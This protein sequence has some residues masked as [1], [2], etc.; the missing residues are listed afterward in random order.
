MH[1]LVITSHFRPE[2]GAAAKRMGGLVLALQFAGHRTTVVTLNA[3]GAKSADSRVTIDAEGDGNQVWRFQNWTPPRNNLRARLWTEARFALLASRF[4]TRMS[5]V[6]GVLASSPYMFNLTA[7]RTYSVP[8]WLD[9]RDLTWEYAREVA[10]NG[11]IRSCGYHFMKATTLGSLRSAL[12]IS[13]TTERQRQFL[14]Q[15]G[16]SADKIRVVANG[17]PHTVAEQLSRL[18]SRPRADGPLRLVYGGTLGLAQGI[19]FALSAIADFNPRELELHLYGE[20]ADGDQLRAYCALRGLKH[21]HF[22]GDVSYDDYLEAIAGADI[23]LASLRNG[24]SFS[25]AMPSKIWEYMAAGRPI[26]FIGSGAAADVVSAAQAGLCAE[27]GDQDGF[28]RQLRRL[29]DSPALRN[30]CG[31]NGRGWVLADHIREFINA[32]WVHA[33]E[34]AFVSTPHLVQARVQPALSGAVANL[35]QMPATKSKRAA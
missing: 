24:K 9:V 18:A 33:L 4:I 10:C 25:T 17:V 12:R 16:I 34:E 13:T 22:H 7:A 15:E 19:G 5:A 8:M 11:L 26:L 20:G 30:E 23:L 29:I 27:Y 31:A 28:R 35:S 6:D 3:A 1:I 2:S 14:I 32:E 21:V